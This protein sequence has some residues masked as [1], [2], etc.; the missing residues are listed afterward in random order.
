MVVWESLGDIR[1]DT[2]SVALYGVMSLLRRKGQVRVREVELVEDV[3]NRLR[4]KLG[5]S[6]GSPRYIFT[7]PRW[8]IGWWWGRCGER[9]RESLSWMR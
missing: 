2:Q 4:R 6:A 7:E 8:D 1:V 9:D 3:M 5:D